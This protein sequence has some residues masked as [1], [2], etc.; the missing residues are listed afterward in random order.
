[1]EFVR[2]NLFL[3]IVA[4]VVLVVGGGMVFMKLGADEDTDKKVALRTGASAS[5][6][7]LA[8]SKISR[9]VVEAEK[10]RVETVQAAA[11]EVADA[12]IKWNRKN[13]PVLSVTPRGATTAIPAFPIDEKQYETLNLKYDVTQTY[14]KKLVAL[15]DPLAPA[16]PPTEAEIEAETTVQAKTIRDKLKRERMNAIA[17]GEEP[18][19]DPGTGAIATQARKKASDVVRLKKASSGM[20]YASEGALDVVFPDPDPLA[21]FEKLWQAQ[22]NLWVTSDILAA[23]Q[24]VNTTATEGAESRNILTSGIKRLLKIDVVNEYVKGKVPL[25]TPGNR[26]GATSSLPI[27]KNL[28]QRVCSQQADVV[29]YS[30]T[31]IMPTKYMLLLQRELMDRNFHTVLGIEMTNVAAEPDNLHY[32]GTDPVMQ[33]TLNCELLLLTAWERGT[34]DAKSKTWTEP[35]LMPVKVLETLEKSS[36]RAEDRNRM[37]EAK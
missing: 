3:I 7:S 17:A 35:A 34:W 2:K 9:R 24:A 30:F 19:A 23:I 36:L 13:Y 16:V 27:E 21:P 37:G 4:A 8:R 32:Y 29:H 31:V 25:A 20:I 28:T 11:K 22:V 12:C 18:P 5:L 33:V 15:L 1:M 14:Y 26:R 6:Q 10:T